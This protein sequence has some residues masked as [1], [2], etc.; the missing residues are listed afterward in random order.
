[1]AWRGGAHAGGGAARKHA[2][3]AYGGNIKAFLCAA[4]ASAG[5]IRRA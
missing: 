1:M 3:A 5:S 4:R 2:A